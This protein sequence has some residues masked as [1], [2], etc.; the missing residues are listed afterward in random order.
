VTSQPEAQFRDTELQLDEALR[1]GREAI[2]AS[3]VEIFDDSERC[4]HYKNE[5]L[6]WSIRFESRRPRGSD[7]E[8]VWGR[9]SVY[10]DDL[11][12]AKIWRRAEVFQTGQSSRWQETD[13]RAIPLG[14]LLRSG[15]A[16]VVA[17]EIEEG[18]KAASAR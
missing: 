13:E 7:I 18:R 9:V 5:R 1:R 17:E 14:D 12:V 16:T 8:K 2:V 10:E 6:S 4:Y 11:T 3:G 15:L